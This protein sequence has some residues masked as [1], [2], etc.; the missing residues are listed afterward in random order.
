M[1]IRKRL[2]YRLKSKFLIWTF[3]LKIKIST[4][5][6]SIQRNTSGLLR[7][8]TSH[9][10]FNKC[11]R[12]TKL[13]FFL[14]LGVLYITLF[15]SPYTFVTEQKPF[16]GDFSWSCINPTRLSEGNF[17]EK[18]RGGLEHYVPK[19]RLLEYE[20]QDGDTLWSISRKF[21][22]YPDSIISCNVFSNV[23]RIYPGEVVLVPNIRG[24]FIT[25]KQGD[26][27]FKYSSKYRVP[28]DFIMEV[29][30]LYTN[31]LTPGMKIFLPGVKFNTMERAFALGEAFDKPAWGRLTSKFGYRRDPITGKRAYHTGVDIAARVGTKVYASRAGQVIYTG[32]RYGY[33]KCVVM[34][35]RFGY[36]TVYAHLSQIF[37]R[38]GQRVEKGKVIGRIG[39]T[40]RSTGPHL[41]FEI[42][43]KNRLIDP[44]TQTNMAIR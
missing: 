1:R 24:I 27:I 22:V 34:E 33:G 44:L 15:P 29:N 39:D 20:V 12:Y 25:V 43:L 19:L 18:G 11:I 8:L 10:D 17:S 9:I 35:H 38:R 26:S 21:G 42:W 14:L 5:F 36:T 2:A 23:H 28:T 7:I 41:H 30:G 4:S 3:L 16:Y 13:A 40:G 31:K 6:R 32:D 37:V